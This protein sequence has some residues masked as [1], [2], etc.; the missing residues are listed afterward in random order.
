MLKPKSILITF[1]S[2]F[3]FIGYVFSSSNNFDSQ[4]KVIATLEYIAHGYEANNHNVAHLQIQ[5][6]LFLVQ[7]AQ[8]GREIPEEKIF[9]PRWVEFE[10]IIKG[11]KRRYEQNL[12]AMPKWRAYALDNNKRLL[13]FVPNAVHIY[14]LQDEESIWTRSI[15][16]YSCFLQLSHYKGCENVGLAMQTYIEQIQKG[17]FN[18]ENQKIS[19]DVNEAGLFKICIKG[20]ASTREYVID[21]NKGFNLIKIKE[22]RPFEKYWHEESGE[23]EYTELPTG[24]WIITKGIIKGLEDGIEYEKRLE[25]SDINVDFEPPDEIFESESLHIPVDIYTVDHCFSPPLILNKGG[26]PDIKYLDALVGSD[27]ANTETAKINHEGKIAV[28]TNQAY[29]EHDSMK[30]ENTVQFPV[31]KTKI[32]WYWFI[33]TLMAIIGLFA[34]TSIYLFLRKRAH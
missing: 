15:D 1:G 21:S 13:T 27:I 8:Q 6:K 19:V 20:E 12:L 10:Y 26:T 34:L 33:F 31:A 32:K 4:D 5:G 22:L 2:L 11:G 23:Y 29:V 3:F 14:P 7:R 17:E 25:T 9:A 16:P 24:Q 30:G 18:Q 28:N